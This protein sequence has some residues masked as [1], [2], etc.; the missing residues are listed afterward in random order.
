MY[1]V[2]EYNNFCKEQIFQIKLI[3]NNLDNAKK[4]AF[5]S[6]KN[7]I[8]K[9]NNIY[10]ITTNIKKFY[11][12]PNHE[13]IVEYMIIEVKKCNKNKFKIKAQ[14]SKI[15]SVIKFE[16]C[17]SIMLLKDIDTRLICN[18]FYLY[19]DVCEFDKLDTLDEVDEI[20]T[21]DDS[22]EIDISDEIYKSDNNNNIN[23]RDNSD[24]IDDIDDSDDSDDSDNIYDLNINT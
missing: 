9:D 11:I 19:D 20:D 2:I 14:F 21:S 24:D 15:Y 6:A 18:D 10:K 22:D 4:I 12:R 3:T 17:V 5:N 13:C 16:N 1:A 8:P 23:D 7:E